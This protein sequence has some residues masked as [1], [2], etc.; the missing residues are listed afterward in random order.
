MSFYDRDIRL[1]S[2]DKCT[3]QDE[4]SD[5][6][7]QYICIDHQTVITKSN[8]TDSTHSFSSMFTVFIRSASLYQYVQIFTFHPNASKKVG[9]AHYKISSGFQFWEFFF[10]QR[11]PK[12][13][14]SSNFF[15]FCWPNLCIYCQRKMEQVL[16]KIYLHIH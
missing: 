9:K 12:Q 5:T 1:R 3:I 8:I 14:V 6:N 4:L 13:I 16:Q 10:W 7:S 11:K 2:N 15:T